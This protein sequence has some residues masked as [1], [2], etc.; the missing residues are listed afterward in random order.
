[1]VPMRG[2]TVFPTSSSLPQVS[3]KNL[4]CELAYF[5]PPNLV[6]PSAFSHMTLKQLTAKMK[7]QPLTKCV[8]TRLARGT[9]LFL[10]YN[11]LLIVYL[12]EKYPVIT[13]VKAIGRIKL[14]K[15]CSSM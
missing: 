8:L 13:G 2:L 11:T 5:F 6:F 3:I 12:D 1:M 10:V 14:K 9:R 15:K 4:Y 7:T